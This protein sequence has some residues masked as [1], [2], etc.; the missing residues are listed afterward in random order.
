MPCEDA[1]TVIR[2]PKALLVPAAGIG[3]VAIFAAPKL[4]PEVLERLSSP[5]TNA[6]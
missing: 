3:N 4:M 5:L 2:R 1:V 6:A